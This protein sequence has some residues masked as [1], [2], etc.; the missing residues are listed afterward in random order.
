MAFNLHSVNGSSPNS[1]ESYG[2]IAAQRYIGLK[3]TYL[4][5]EQFLDTIDVRFTEAQNVEDGK[6]NQQYFSDLKDFWQT[7]I[8]KFDIDEDNELSVNEYKTFTMIQL[9]LQKAKDTINEVYTRTGLIQM[10]A[11][12]I[13]AEGTKS[14]EEALLIASNHFNQLDDQQIEA[15]KMEAIEGIDIQDSIID[16]MIQ[17]VDFD[18]SGALSVEELASV[19][20]SADQITPLVSQA[21]EKKKEILKQLKEL[22]ENEKLKG[23]LG[24][25]FSII[26]SLGELKLAMEGG[27][28]SKANQTVLFNNKVKFDGE[29]SYVENDLSDTLLLEHPEYYIPIIKKH[30]ETIKQ[31]FKSS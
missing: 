1:G 29:I 24:I 11:S 9:Q 26:N 25:F 27:S 16:E 22:G 2:K 4:S 15:M 7:I 17:K 28:V 12:A 14:K 23:E 13:E 6:A 5:Q 3:N 19:D 31:A 21:N 20:Y 18:G 10:N 8:K 30:Y